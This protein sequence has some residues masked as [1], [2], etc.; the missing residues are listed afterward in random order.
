MRANIYRPSSSG[1]HPVIMTVGPYGKDVHFGDRNPDAYALIAEHGP[2][3]NWETPNPEWW[4][5]RGYVVVRVD[6]RGIGASPGRLDLFSQQQ[7]E[8]F[9]AP[10][11]QD[12]EVTDPLALRLWVSSSTTELDLFVT[13]RNVDPD[14]NDVSCLGSNI[15]SLTRA[16][17]TP[18]GSAPRRAP[19]RR[20]RSSPHPSGVLGL[21]DSSV[22]PRPVL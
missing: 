15:E 12:T 13:I 16:A 9:T 4:V 11:A 21:L 10:F 3:L 1:Q 22:P 6:Q 2:Y 17:G 20:E 18:N 5:P 19:R 7:G 14:G 8:D